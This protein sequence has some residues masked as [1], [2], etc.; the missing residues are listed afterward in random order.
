V[1]AVLIER[2]IEFQRDIRRRMA[3]VLAGPNERQRESIKARGNEDQ[4]PGP[5]F[6]VALT[7]ISVLAEKLGLD[8]RHQLADHLDVP[9]EK[10]VARCRGV[11]GDK[12][13]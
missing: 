12:E 5:L 8:G 1:R 9:V 4:N 10:F 13:R 6:R 7:R 11:I 3:L 2:E